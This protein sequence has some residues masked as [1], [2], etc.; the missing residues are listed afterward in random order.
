MKKN[1]FLFLSAVVLISIISFI[2]VAVNT[3]NGD[4][5]IIYKDGKIYQEVDLS[6]NSEIIIGTTNSVITENGCI[7]MSRASCPDKLCMRQGRISDSS[8]KIICLPNKIVIEVKRKSEIDT[9]V[10]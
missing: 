8:K 4:T 7:Y 9:V 6:K 5:A 10:R 2:F 3:E 1:D